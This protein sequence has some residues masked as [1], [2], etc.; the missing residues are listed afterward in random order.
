MPLVPYLVVRRHANGFS[1]RVFVALLAVVLVAQFLI[2][3]QILFTIV[4]VGVIAACAAA[5]ILGVKAVKRTIVESVVALIVAAVIVGPI[6]V[7]AFVSNERAPARS[8]FAGSADLLNYVIPTRRTWLR[9]AGAEA[10]TDRFTGSGAEHGAYLGIPL[11]VLV[12]IAAVPAFRRPVLRGRLWLVSVLVCLVVLSLGTR[13]KVAGHVVGIGPWTALARIPVLGSALPVRLTMYVALLAALLIAFALA[14]RRSALRWSLAVL[15]IIA[16][17][18]NLGLP[19]WSSDVPRPQ[20]FARNAQTSYLTADSTALVLPYG[21]AG[22]SMLWQAQ[23]GFGFR[24]IGG[25]FA[26]RVTP[27]EEQWRDVYEALGT[28]RLSPQ[29]L[30]AFLTTHA[31]D[32]VIVAPGTRPRVQRVVEM[33]LGG[34]PERVLDTL[35][36]RVDQGQK[37]HGTGSS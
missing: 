9:P 16:I 14:D 33:A 10:I 26:L 12:I 23:A 27:D 25:H 30:R 36:F 34:N 20:F 37:P 2:V 19:Q 21:P 24:M 6:L 5:V 18:P 8:A 28:G 7:Y 31:V 11:L 3:T 35:V 32:A 29:R 15:G 22:W 4:V 13:V 17:L 1:A